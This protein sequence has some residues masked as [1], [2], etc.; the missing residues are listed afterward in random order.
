MSN[1]PFDNYVGNQSGHVHPSVIG[2]PYFSP[3][4]LQR[5]ANEIN[6]NLLQGKPSTL[7]INEVKNMFNN[8]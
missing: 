5:I 4:Q 2:M 3:E 1:N 7:N 6:K 8:K